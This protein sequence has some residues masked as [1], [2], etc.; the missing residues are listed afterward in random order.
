MDPRGRHA[1]LYLNERRTGSITIKGANDSWHFGEF[2]PAPSFASFATKFGEWSL[3]MHAQELDER[4]DDA[5]LDELRQVEQTIDFL[6]AKIFFPETKVW[7][8][9]SQLNIDG[10][11]IE[12]KEA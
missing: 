10:P 5:A 9:V 8:R 11:L 4:L 2:S 6:H 12:W 7:Q 1:E 3:L